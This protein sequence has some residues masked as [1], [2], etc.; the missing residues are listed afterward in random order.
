MKPTPSRHLRTLAADLEAGRPINPAE[1]ASLVRIAAAMLD[2]PPDDPLDA[3]PVFDVENGE[4]GPSYDRRPGFEGTI[5]VAD[6]GL[7]LGISGAW[8]NSTLLGGDQPG[9]FAK[10]AARAIRR[11]D[12]H[13][14]DAVLHAD[15]ARE[16][17]VVLY[18]A[19]ERAPL[20][21]AATDLWRNL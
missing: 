6:P 19:A 17:G 3:F 20:D 1:A 18:G 15:V 16:L 12:H 7:V 11:Q 8:A 10:F 5:A 2:D 21:Q 9:V 13:E 14:I 4:L